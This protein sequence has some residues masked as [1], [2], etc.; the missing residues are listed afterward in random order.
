M[1]G[2][3]VYRT[4]FVVGAEFICEREPRNRHSDWAIAVKKPGSGEV[5]GHV[6]DDLARVLFPLLTSGKILSM[7]SEVTGLSKAAEEGVWVQGGGIVI[8]CTYVLRGKKLDRSHVRSELR[9][10]CR[11]KREFV[12]EAGTEP[13]EK[14]KRL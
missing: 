7:T 5:T 13:V 11:K 8:P 6:P 10:N 1:K 14:C 12:G 2:H 9:K 4:A 3:H